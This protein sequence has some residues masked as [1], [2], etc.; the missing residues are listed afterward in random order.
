VTIIP[1]RRIVLVSFLAL[2]TVGCGGDDG[3]GEDTDGGGGVAT[4]TLVG[5]YG[6]DTSGIGCIWEGN[7]VV[8]RDGTGDVIG[9]TTMDLEGK[10]GSGD[11]CVG[12]ASFTVD[13]PEPTA[14]YY[15]IEIET[16]LAGG[17]QNIRSDLIR[18]EDVRDARLHA[19][20]EDRR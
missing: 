8:V 3:G 5:H 20:A 16:D 18:F 14:G 10:V 1:V 13:V 6:G 2:A 9:T 12:Q 17:T 19:V 11:N 7:A 4:H 15:R